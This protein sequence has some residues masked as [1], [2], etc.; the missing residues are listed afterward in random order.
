ML[1]LG[2]RLV[3][4]LDQKI[5]RPIIKKINDS[6]QLNCVAEDAQASD[7]NGIKFAEVLII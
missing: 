7:N 4:E 2:V 3:L 1:N 6:S 5:S